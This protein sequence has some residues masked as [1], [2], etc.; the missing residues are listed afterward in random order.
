MTQNTVVGVLIFT[1]MRASILCAWVTFSS[2]DRAPER[3]TVN[4]SLPRCD[5]SRVITD[6]LS[7]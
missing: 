6:D 5:N 4:S 1:H 3:E 2:Q 7:R